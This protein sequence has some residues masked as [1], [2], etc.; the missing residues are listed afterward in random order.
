MEFMGVYA[1]L[2]SRFCFYQF[3]GS[4]DREGKIFRKNKLRVFNPKAGMSWQ[5]NENNSSV[6]RWL[7]L[8]KNLSVTISVN[9]LKVVRK[10]KIHRI[11]KLVTVLV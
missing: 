1:D 6:C 10:R 7:L 2:Q 5:I 4:Y 3:I 9:S 11:L 8:I